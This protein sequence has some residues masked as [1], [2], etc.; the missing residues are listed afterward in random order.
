MAILTRKYYD[1]LSDIFNALYRDKLDKF[2]KCEV[3]VIRSS[4]FICFIVFY[5]YNPNLHSVGYFG[6]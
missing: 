1:I 6:W 2:N 4:V 5:R 3:I